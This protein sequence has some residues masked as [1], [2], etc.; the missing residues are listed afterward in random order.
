MRVTCGARHRSAG[1]ND[2]VKGGW[3]GRSGASLGP[4]DAGE[5]IQ[6]FPQG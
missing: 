1:F 5:K 4:L 2:W 3:C 6:A